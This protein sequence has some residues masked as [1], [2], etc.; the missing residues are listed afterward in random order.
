MAARKSERLTGPQID[1]VD[2]WTTVGARRIHGARHRALLLEGG[3]T[4]RVCS[5]EHNRPLT[6]NTHL[7]LHKHAKLHSPRQLIAARYGPG[8]AIGLVK[9]VLVAL[10]RIAGIEPSRAQFQMLVE[11]DCPKRRRQRVL[12]PAALRHLKLHRLIVVMDV[13]IIL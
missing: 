8:P 12:P 6:L 1:H 7:A 5:A 4:V 10:I 13:C 3:P 2:R 9:S 11:L